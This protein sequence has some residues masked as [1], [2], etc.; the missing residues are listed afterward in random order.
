MSGLALGVLH[1]QTTPKA[2]NQQLLDDIRGVYGKG[3]TNSTPIRSR[4]FPAPTDSV[5]VPHQPGAD[6]SLFNGNNPFSPAAAARKP[7]E[8]SDDDVVVHSGDTPAASPS[9]SGTGAK[10]AATAP[11]PAAASAAANSAKDSDNESVVSHSESTPAQSPT[12]ED[13]RRGGGSF[14]RQ[15]QRRSCLACIFN[16]LCAPCRLLAR[17]VRRLFCCS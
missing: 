7:T 13:E 1:K 14:S 16:I 17:L 4:Y 10:V 8:D 9:R 3:P 11:T 12:V 5:V 2:L 6:Y 15:S